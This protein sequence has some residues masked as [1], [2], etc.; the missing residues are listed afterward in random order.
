MQHARSSLRF[1]IVAMAALA[2]GTGAAA[3]DDQPGFHFGGQQR[4]R[5]E[6]LN[7][8]FRAGYSD[9]DQALALQTSVTFDWH[10]DGLQVFG[11]IMDSRVELNDARSFAN[12]ST[13]NALEPIQAFI[14]WRHGASTLK[15]GRFT[16][17]IGKR[18][19]VARA[20][21]NNTVTSFAG[22][23]WSWS[24]KGGRAVRAFHWI[25]LRI[26][27]T[28]LP[29]VLDND[30]ELDRGTRGS[31]ATGIFYQFPTRPNG[32]Q[33]ETYLFDYEFESL[34]A[35][36]NAADHRSLGARVY[37]AQKVGEWSYEAEGILQRGT[38]GGTVARVARADLAHRASLLHL[39]LGYTFDRKAAPTLSFVYDLVSGDKSPID[40]RNERFNTLAG[41]RRFEYGPTNIYG[42]IPRANIASPGA[43]LTFRPKPIWQ[44]ML[45]LRGIALDEPRDAWVGS[46]WRDTSGAAGTHVGTQFEGSF[47]WR[48]IPDRLSVEF[49]FAEVASG[50][51]AKQTAG[52]AYRGDPHYFYA[53][54]LTTF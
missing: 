15:A 30:V 25:P 44:G 9:S 37:N 14:A 27:P 41:D 24:G 35:A 12:A 6:T 23:D 43:R 4:T 39:E 7:N 2:L 45:A 31:S 52:L 11:E 29:S 21:Y 22:I 34:G 1:S 40:L 8:Q 42:L 26:L 53:T 47:T 38:S 46:G 54:L 33:L 3:A 16:A 20:R 10:G 36:A 13:T 48:A 5:Y 19:L 18:R 50:R 51:F 28:D 49:G 32:L 17:D